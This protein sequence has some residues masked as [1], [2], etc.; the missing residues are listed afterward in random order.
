MRF[1]MMILWLV[2]VIGCGGS[3]PAPAP[4]TPLTLDNWKQLPKEIKYDIDT[5][6]RLRR[7]D[8]KYQ[9]QRDWDRFSRETILPERKK[10]GVK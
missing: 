9:N 2:S 7:S 5:L 10:D 1:L 4:E 8:P 6:E 3:T